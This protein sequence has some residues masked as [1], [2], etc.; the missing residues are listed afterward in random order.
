MPYFKL[1]VQY[2]ATVESFILALSIQ[3][4]IIPKQV[5]KLRDIFLNLQLKH[6]ASLKT[7]KKFSVKKAPSQVVVLFGVKNLRGI[8]RWVC[9]IGLSFDC[10]SYKQE[11]FLL[12]SLKAYS[13]YEYVQKKIK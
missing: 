8:K 2:I 10:L 11:K 9:R 12:I 7:A 6:Q 1:Y 4:H 5:Y 3:K 13:H